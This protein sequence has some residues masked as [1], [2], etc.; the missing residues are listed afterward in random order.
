MHR[1]SGFSL[2]EV[3]I[4]IVILAI[5]L[6][7]MAGLTAASIRNN[8]GSYHRTQAVWLA[9]DIADRMRANRQ[10]ALEGDY[11]TQLGDAE[12][13]GASV[14]D[15]DLG[16]WKAALSALPEGDGAV[17]VN[18]DGQVTITVQW[19]ETRAAGAAAN[20]DVSDPDNDRE[21]KFV[22]QTQL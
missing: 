11:N 14:S 9:Y 22:V 12:P 15:G 21:R 13:G 1:E 16:Q 3:L 19:N 2:L 7:G 17:N 5:G 10:K 4:T 6:L 18:N 20:E 8:H